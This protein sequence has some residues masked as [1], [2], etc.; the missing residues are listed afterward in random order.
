MKSLIL[1]YKFILVI[2]LVV[3]F[4][5][6]L[7]QY[8]L[9][10]DNTNPSNTQTISET[11]KKGDITQSISASGQVQTANYL[12]ITTSVNGIVKQVFV[13]EGD[14]VTQGQKIMEVTLDSEGER[15]RLNSYSSYLKAKNSL[16]AAKNNLYSLESTKLQEEEVFR[17]L[18][19]NN[20]YQSHDE[21]LAYKLAENDAIKAK[22]DYDSQ[23][24][25]ILQ[26]QISLSDAWADYQAQFPII[27]SPTDG[28]VANIISVE[29]TKIENS[30]ADR[31]IRTVASIKKEGTP[32]VSV[33]VNELDI[34]KVKVGQK[35][36]I[37][38]NSMPESEFAGSVVGIDKI[39]MVQSGVS[40]YPVIIK[41]DSDN[42][43]ILPNMG[44]EAGIIVE[45]KSG[46]LLVPS[47]AISTSRNGKAVK[48]V[49]GGGGTTDVLIITGI[50]DETNTEIMSGLNEGDIVEINTLPTQGFTTQTQI[51]NRGLGGFGGLGSFGTQQR[52]H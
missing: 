31:S 32:I 25:T 20:S 10:K 23:Q 41:L 1:K 6:F 17:D 33:N 28:I 46:V 35:V 38:L 44:A 51:Q 24:S 11:V 52:S 21:R 45:T 34:N 5:V 30:V 12:S 8:L 50:S 13:K 22:N 7:G 15:S 47:S 49:K 27:T 42:E 2:I 43:Q 3:G 14:R 29:G 36:N 16:D 26:L 48:V 39:G 37:K 4:V 18:K 19:E 9:N 40:N